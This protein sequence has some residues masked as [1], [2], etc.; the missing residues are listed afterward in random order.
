MVICSGVAI[1][2]QALRQRILQGDA[3]HSVASNRLVRGFLMPHVMTSIT[4]ITEELHSEAD[5]H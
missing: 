2:N 5:I 1:L 4:S 3:A